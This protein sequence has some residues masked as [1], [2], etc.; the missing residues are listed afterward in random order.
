MRM[1]KAKQLGATVARAA[2]RLAIILWRHPEPRPRSLVGHIRQRQRFGHDAVAADERAA[3]LVRIR[4]STVG[5]NRRMNLRIQ[6]QSH[7]RF[8]GPEPP[9]PLRGFGEPRGSAPLEPIFAP[10]WSGASSQK[11]SDKYFSPPSG[12]ITTI[13]ESGDRLATVSAAARFAPLEIPTKS[14]L[15][16]S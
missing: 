8:R 11:R 14:P 9:S 12:K 6:L 15:R 4:F 13:T 10:R 5:T 1:V 16:A 7:Y 2:L 3:A